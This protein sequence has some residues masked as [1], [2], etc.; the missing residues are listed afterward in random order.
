MTDP[1]VRSTIPNSYVDQKDGFSKKKEVCY[2]PS[3]WKKKSG[4]GEKWYTKTE[5]NLEG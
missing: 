5:G 1:R 4:G 3:G 2:I